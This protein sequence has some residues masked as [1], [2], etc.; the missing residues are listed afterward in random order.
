MV[1]HNNGK[2]PCPQAN[3][4]LANTAR[5]VVRT[6]LIEPLVLA[7]SS[8]TNISTRSGPAASRPGWTN[9]PRS[10]S[11]RRSAGSAPLSLLLALLL[12]CS[13]LLSDAPPRR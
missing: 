1:K 8:H 6:P 12:V 3:A 11:A 2:Q 9:P 7:Q 5:S 10:A 4:A 13:A